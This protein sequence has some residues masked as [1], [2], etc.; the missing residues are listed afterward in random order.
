MSYTLLL[1][2]LLILLVLLLLLLVLLLLQLLLLL[3]AASLFSSILIFSEIVSLTVPFENV[4]PFRVSSCT[5][6][7]VVSIT[8]WGT[9]A[10]LPPSTWAE[11]VPLSPLSSI[12]FSMLLRVFSVSF[13]VNVGSLHCC[14][15]LCSDL[16]SFVGSAASVI[17]FD[18]RGGFV[19]GSSGGYSVLDLFLISSFFVHTIFGFAPGSFLC[20]LSLVL[21]FSVLPLNMDVEFSYGSGRHN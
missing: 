13:L 18:G 3:L 8:F 6:F 12:S 17:F 19:P 21:S 16:Y 2:L 7:P 1:L 11:I 15:Y 10:T 4:I 20:P 14:L 9:A 5:M